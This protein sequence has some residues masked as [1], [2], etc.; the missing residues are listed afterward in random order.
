MSRTTVLR[1]PPHQLDL[2]AA[3][4]A[5]LWRQRLFEA[6]AGM[7]RYLAARADDDVIA[8]WIRTRSALFADLPGD[9]AGPDGWQAIFFRGQAL[10]ERFLV[11]RFGHEAMREWAGRNAEVHAL[12]ERDRGGGARDPI[13][14]IARQAELYGSTYAIGPAGRE[15]ATVEISHCAIWDYREQARA[16]GVPLTLRSPC[17]YCTKSMAAN[18][19]ARGYEPVYELLEHDDGP[20]CRWT[21]RARGDRQEDGACAA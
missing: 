5:A 12:V 10:M 9:D 21:A 11:S 1:P 20:G 4:H 16:R 14:R 8:S 15:T 3:E 2:S 18:V 6:E 7:T 17:E 13:E 19:A